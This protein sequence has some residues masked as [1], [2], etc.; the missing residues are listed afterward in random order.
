M[1]AL[2]WL[3]TQM[4]RT[5]AKKLLASGRVHVNGVSITRH[6]HVVN[7]TDRVTIVAVK[8]TASLT[9]LY[10]DDHIIAI[11]KPAGLLSVATDS[12]KLDTAFVRLA[13]MLP[14][15]PFVVHR[16]DRET[17]GVLLFAKTAQVRD[18]L[19][20]EWPM[21]RKEYLAAVD[22]PEV[23]GCI[24]CFLRE[25]RDLRVS[26]S[27]EYRPGSKRAISQVWVE[28]P[29]IVRV[30]IKTGRKHQVRVHLAVLGSPIIGDVVYGGRPAERMMLHSWRL[31]LTVP[32][33]V[34]I[35]SPAPF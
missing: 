28:R 26:W 12:E 11:D 6:D 4:N 27:A 1:T 32:R 34:V 7:E 35:E 31:T 20:T 10:Q 25:E 15:R 21:V 33:P 18:Q 29:G 16:L 30:E 24:E 13:A 14:Q 5:R 19:Q 3:L 9:I 2:D 22:G 17:S 23:S 8:P